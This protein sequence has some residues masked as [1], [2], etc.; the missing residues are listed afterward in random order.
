[1]FRLIPFILLLI[2]NLSF[3]YFGMEEAVCRDKQHFVECF[4]WEEKDCLIEARKGLYRCVS[5]MPA[6][7]KPKASLEEELAEPTGRSAGTWGILLGHC[8]EISMYYRNTGKMDNNCKGYFEARVSSFKDNQFGMGL[9]HI[10]KANGW[11]LP[12]EIDFTKP[13]NPATIV[14]GINKT[15]YHLMKTL[16]VNLC[17]GLLP[18]IILAWL[19]WM[20]TKWNYYSVALSLAPLSWLA[21][22]C[23]DVFSK[24]FAKSVA[25][26]GDNPSAMAP[27]FYSWILLGILYWPTL[28]LIFRTTRVKVSVIK[29]EKESAI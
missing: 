13:L 2:S 26:Y 7:P 6:Q 17:G 28:Y 16:L 29:K 27:S 5:V 1:M 12:P 3:S 22:L 15:K 25:I 9:G 18:F 11:R 10:F 14:K 23:T 4:N 21:S 19:I 20:K 24:Q 8:A